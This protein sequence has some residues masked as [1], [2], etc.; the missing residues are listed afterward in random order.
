MNRFRRHSPVVIESSASEDGL[1]DMEIVIQT[2]R[3]QLSESEIP[4]LHHPL[5]AASCE[6]S[7]EDL[8]RA[9]LQH[10]TINCLPDLLSSSHHLDNARRMCAIQAEVNK[11]DEVTLR[12]YGMNTA[13]LNQR[14]VSLWNAHG[15]HHPN[16]GASQII[17]ENPC[18]CGSFE[19][20]ARCCP[21]L[22]PSMPRTQRERLHNSFF[23]P[24]DATEWEHARQHLHSVIPTLHTH[25]LFWM[26]P[27]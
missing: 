13:V 7:L 11:M 18:L 23:C 17:L 6:L 27:Q 26:L 15:Q 12:E 14:V 10:I 25:P 21:R 8:R 24:R 3:L 5:D 9:C 1:D 16:I 19:H 2:E 20:R 22:P 4:R